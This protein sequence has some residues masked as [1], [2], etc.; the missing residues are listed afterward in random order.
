MLKEIEREITNT[1]LYSLPKR[2]TG[3]Q[4]Y[5]VLEVQEFVQNGLHFASGWM[6]HE[7]FPQDKLF[8]LEVNCKDLGEFLSYVENMDLSEFCSD[9]LWNARRDKPFEN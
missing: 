2:L 5:F 9:Y 6:F 4:S 3:G 1:T 8:L 7:Y